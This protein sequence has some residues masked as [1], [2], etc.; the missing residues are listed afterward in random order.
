[1]MNEAK[2]GNLTEASCHFLLANKLADHIRKYGTTR[3]TREIRCMLQDHQRQEWEG[4]VMRMFQSGE[5]EIMHVVFRESGKNL[6][7]MPMKNVQTLK[8]SC[9]EM[10][11]LGHHYGTSEVQTK[12]E[13]RQ[14]GESIKQFHEAW[15]NRRPGED[16]QCESSKVHSSVLTATYR[17]ST[18]Y[19]DV[20]QE[21]MGIL[22]L[23]MLWKSLRTGYAPQIEG[24]A[25]SDTRGMLAKN[26]TTV[27]N[28]ETLN[29]MF[30][31]IHERHTS[32]TEEMEYSD[33][34]YED[35]RNMCHAATP[36]MSRM[37]DASAHLSAQRVMSDFTAL[38]N[39]ITRHPGTVIEEDINKLCQDHY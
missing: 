32:L 8:I 16:L 30:V 3:Q 37:A 35:I 12:E 14:L 38:H 10:N 7:K 13:G 17:L 39:L 20:M 29:N 6:T 9:N 1:M 2:I 28:N 33:I 36:K 4:N 27:S 15:I 19:P 25:N 18:K 22:D 26:L 23:M 34:T 31:C 24:R 5:E 21:T 11:K